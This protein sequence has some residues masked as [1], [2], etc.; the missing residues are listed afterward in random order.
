MA[1]KTDIT[2]RFARAVLFTA[3]LGISAAYA[4]AFRTSGAPAW[5]PW[6]LAI[7]IPAALVAIMILGAARGSNG[8]GSLKIP[9]LFVFIVL[10]GGFCLALALPES[11][12]KGAQLLFG[13]PLRA[14]ILIYGVGLLPTFVLPIAYALTFQT[15]TL[16]EADIARVREVAERTRARANEEVS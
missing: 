8:I 5:A 3:I 4:S 1:A 12:G 9:F 14:A 7:G 16:S 10:A 2:R 11:E 6:L 13:L 15:Q